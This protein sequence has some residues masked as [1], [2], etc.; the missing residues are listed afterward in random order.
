M[1][2]SSKIV[3][4][5]VDGPLLS[6]RARLHPRN[7][8]AHAVPP[9]PEPI[10]WKI[11]R[12]PR[13]SEAIRYFDELGVSLILKLLRGHGAQLVISSSWQK[14]GL[15]NVKYILEENSISASFLHPYWNTNGGSGATRAQEISAWLDAAAQ[16]DED[17][18]AFAAIDDDQSIT[19][20]AG[21]ILVS[22]CDGIRWGDFCSA[23]AALGGGFEVS[24]L[25]RKDGKLTGNM[26]KGP[27][28]EIVISG[29]GVRNRRFEF[30][31][32]ENDFGPAPPGCI[33]LRTSEYQLVRIDSKAHEF[34]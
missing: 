22:Y 31:L 29:H 7:Q 34:F 25:E 14:A 5:D 33:R 21:G 8:E 4:L 9:L 15:A 10:D 23:S 32:T 18:Q 28:E 19:T 3:F 12:A 27:L 6:H 17:I 20:L 30:P 1:T 11:I 16:R 2:N 13:G 24:D 26:T